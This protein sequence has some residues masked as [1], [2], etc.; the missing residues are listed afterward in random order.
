MI[1]N[2]VLYGSEIRTMRKEDIKRLEAFEMRIWIRGFRDAGRRS[3]RSASR[4]DYL[5]PRSYTAIKQN[6]AFSAAGP[7]IWNGLPFELRSLPRDFSSS[8]Y[9]LLKTFHFCPGLGW[10]RF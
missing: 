8:F 9:S 1:W 10:E 6:R 7:S 3:L 2:V 4:G 5:I